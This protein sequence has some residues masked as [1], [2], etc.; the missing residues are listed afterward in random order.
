MF[1]TIFNRPLDSAFE[2]SL[3]PISSMR[4]F[5]RQRDK[6]CVSLFKTL[7]LMKVSELFETAMNEKPGRY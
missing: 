7:R 5:P 6:I 4:L 3:M 2:M 1:A